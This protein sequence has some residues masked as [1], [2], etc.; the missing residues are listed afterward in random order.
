MNFPSIAQIK[1]KGFVITFLSVIFLI[2]PGVLVLFL[3][4][5]SLFINIDWVKLILL[6]AAITAPI[7]FVNTLL[8]TVIDDEDKPRQKDYLF[9]SFSVGI[10]LSSILICGLLFISYVLNAT[11]KDFIF[12]LGVF[13]FF[14]ALAAGVFEFSKGFVRWLKRKK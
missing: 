13:E 11:T 2:L 3:F 6:S 9:D 8:I 4:E 12:T 14:A 1:D 10:V 7:S 5:R